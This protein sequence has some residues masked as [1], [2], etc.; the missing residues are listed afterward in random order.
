M[1]AATDLDMQNLTDAVKEEAHRLGFD[2]VGVTSPD[3]P[4]HLDVY[5][6]WLRAGRHGGMAYLAT[7]RNR[8]RRADPRRILPE[9]ESILV[10]GANY[11]PER[12]ADRSAQPDLRVA[13]YAQGEDYH[14]VLI[15]RLKRLMASLEA[16]AGRS[17]PNR[18]YTDT[19]PL[20]ERELA[21]R[22]GLGWIGKNT[23]LIHPQKGS[24]FL[25]AEALLGIPLVPD[26]PFETDHCGSCTR[27]IEACPTGC[28]LPDRTIDAR[29][30]ISYLTIEEK[31][32]IDPELRP[33]V[34]DWLFGCDV[35]QDVCPWNL[36]FA[37][38]T[39]DP[40]FQPRPALDPPNLPRFLSLEPGSWR[41]SLRASPLERPRRRGLVRNAAVVA[42]NR[43]GYANLPLLERRLH[44]DPEPLV[45]GHSAWAIGRIGGPKAEAALERAS[46]L[47]QDEAVR[48][49]IRRA[50]EGRRSLP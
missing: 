17:V 35:C 5:R 25:L 50:Q 49:E 3:P 28:I 7:E 10:L 11:L 18:I 4:E 27:C 26:P 12:E 46:R 8:R 41:D 31:G 15:E 45:R 30:C 23:C 13:K 39:T 21:M 36:R 33:L 16:L 2:L 37:R 38:T 9:C 40:A 34:D 20:L 48:E 14:Q 24:Y 42:G 6:E 44:H 22:A 32:V 19:G 29:R 47:E 43:G 1:P